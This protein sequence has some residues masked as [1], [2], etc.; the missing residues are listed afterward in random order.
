MKFSHCVNMKKK[1]F[2]RTL[3]ST[4][5]KFLCLPPNENFKYGLIGCSQNSYNL[6]IVMH[7]MIL[8]IVSHSVS[9]YVLKILITRDT[10]WFEHPS[11]ILDLHWTIFEVVL[12]PLRY[13]NIILNS[14]RL[15][16]TAKCKPKL[17][18]LNENPNCQ[19]QLI[20]LQNLS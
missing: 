15:G 16:L 5:S 4:E 11:Q 14:Y 6:G 13:Q 2:K 10:V 19:E 12:R 20:L 17:D 9:K 3:S 7:C 18:R 8:N 1:L